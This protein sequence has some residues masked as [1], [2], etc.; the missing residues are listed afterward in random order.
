MLV[1]GK[2]SLFFVFDSNACNSQS[3]AFKTGN[4]KLHTQQWA[5]E[6]SYKQHFLVYR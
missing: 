6:G 1:C 2:V 4:E 5:S 3:L